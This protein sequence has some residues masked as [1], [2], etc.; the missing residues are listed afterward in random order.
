[1]IGQR[2]Y[3][4]RILLSLT[5]YSDP[6]MEECVKMMQMSLR[7][8]PT[9]RKKTKTVK[10]QRNIGTIK[11]RKKERRLQESDHGDIILKI[12]RMRPSTKDFVGQQLEVSKSYSLTT[13]LTNGYSQ[14]KKSIAKNAK[15]T[16]IASSFSSPNASAN[17]STNTG[18]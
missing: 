14:M 4:Y 3:I 18:A 12:L 10:S 17:T 1:M 5:S 7:K 16:S 6:L 9:L 11:A 2:R 13:R 8:A 15:R